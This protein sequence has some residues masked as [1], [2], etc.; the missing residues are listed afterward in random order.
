MAELT[1][2]CMKNSVIVKENRELALV[3]KADE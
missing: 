2:V 1:L 3:A